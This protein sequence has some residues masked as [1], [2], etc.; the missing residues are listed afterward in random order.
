MQDAYNCPH[1]AAVAARHSLRIPGSAAFPVVEEVS[2]AEERWRHA[3]GL[4]GGEGGNERAEYSS[5]AVA[6]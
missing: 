6:A 5:I 4:D 2:E 3:V 1:L